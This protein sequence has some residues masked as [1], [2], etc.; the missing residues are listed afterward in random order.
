M[1]SIEFQPTVRV[2]LMNNVEEAAFTLQGD[3]FDAKQR[4]FVAGKYRVLADA[5]GQLV[6]DDGTGKSE[7]EPDVFSLDFSYDKCASFTVHA[8]T[9]GLDFHWQRQE[10][11]Q[12][13]GRL[14]IQRNPNGKLL[15]INEVNVEDYLISVI[16]SEMSAT[17]HLELLK[18]HAI[19]SRSWL[20][21]Q[22]PAWQSARVQQRPPGWQ[23]QEFINW[24]DRDN[25]QCF[26]I[27]AD[28][29]CQRY[30]GIAKDGCVL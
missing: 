23:G 13:K 1:Q 25:H 29:H 17:A 5:A 28:D 24:Y 3:W 30:Q 22:L 10:D 20:L 8:V 16:S 4:A 12:F 14:R 15:V 18:A 7:K 27:C 26:D 6:I 21:A 11:Q 19:I 2:G 9:I